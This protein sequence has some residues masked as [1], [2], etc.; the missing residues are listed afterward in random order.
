MTPPQIPD[1]SDGRFSQSLQRG[2]AILRLFSPACPDLGIADIGDHLE[3]PRATVHRYVSTLVALDFLERLSSRRYRLGPRAAEFGMSAL[4]ATGLRGDSRA[5]LK[6]LRNRTAL[7]ASIAVL[8]NTEIVYVD[9]ARSNLLGGSLLGLKQRPGSRLPAHCTAMGK[10]L[11]AALPLPEQKEVVSAITFV[12]CTPRT[13][14]TEPELDDELAEV[15]AEGFAVNNEEWTLGVVAIAVPVR[16]APGEVR[17]AVGLVAQCAG[18]SLDRL[19]EEFVPL[20]ASTA[21]TVAA[22]LQ[23]GRETVR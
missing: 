22:G 2:L 6:E 13:I 10:V 14:S 11:L 4:R 7:T 18:V 19:A 16:L 23:R 21:D 9:R 20:A 8:D 5:H 1:L 3:M 17:A 12:Q 15:R